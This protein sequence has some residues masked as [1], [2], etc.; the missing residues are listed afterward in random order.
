MLILTYGP[1]S[2]MSPPRR[3]RLP[4]ISKKL[5]PQKI[6]HFKILQSPCIRGSY[7]LNFIPK[8]S[9]Q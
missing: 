7:P 3:Y 1:K 5:R 4:K 8:T 2:I 6:Y 9:F